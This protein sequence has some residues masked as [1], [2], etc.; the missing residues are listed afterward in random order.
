MGLRTYGRGAAIA[1]ELGKYFAIIAVV[2]LLIHFFAFTIFVVSGKSME[3]NFHNKEV[4]LI[5]KFNLFTNRF[6]R[7]APMVLRFPGDPQHKKYIKRLIGLPGETV[8]IK[9]NAIY[10]NG[11]K[12]TE[13][14]ISTDYSTEPL[15]N[16]NKWTLGTGEYFLVGDNRNNS[17]DSRVWGVAQRSDMV[18]PVV[19]ILI[20]RLEFT[21]APMY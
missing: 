4:V 12:L 20:P 16:Q 8:E 11:D 1:F 18:G 14:Y 2:V 13:S 6:A 17:S 15:T 10:I 9:N 5:N 21:P 3:S 19:M 7:G